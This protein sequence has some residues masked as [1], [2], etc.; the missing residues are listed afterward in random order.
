MRHDPGRDHDGGVKLS[1]IRN[2]T[3]CALSTRKK[4]ER[5]K[6]E[7]DALPLSR[8]RT[9]IQFD[10]TIS[11]LFFC[12]ERNI[13]RLRRRDVAETRDGKWC[14]G[15]RRTFL[16]SPSRAKIVGF[17]LTRPRAPS[18][19]ARFEREKPPK[20]NNSRGKLSCPLPSPLL[21]PLLGLVAPQ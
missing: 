14:R 13:R 17:S 7:R 16:H 3:P 19:C 11:F 2:W 21:F 18:A 4:K 10:R 15:H 9:V 12:G 1:G 5:E 6:E 20:Y 8:N